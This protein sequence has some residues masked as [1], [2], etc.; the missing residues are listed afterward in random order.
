MLDLI[1]PCIVHNKPY[2][3]YQQNFCFIYTVKLQ[4]VIK[5]SQVN[6]LSWVVSD[7]KEYINHSP[8]LIFVQFSY[9]LN[10]KSGESLETRLR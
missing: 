2:L 9:I 3:D 8:E 1:Q 5:T 10:Q 7:L 6:Q 4:N